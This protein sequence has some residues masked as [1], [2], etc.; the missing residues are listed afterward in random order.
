ML[1]IVAHP[2]LSIVVKIGESDLFHFDKA[3]FNRK[4]LNEEFRKDFF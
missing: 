4:Y 2:S 1:E 3:Y